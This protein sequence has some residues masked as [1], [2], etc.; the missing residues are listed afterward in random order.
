MAPHYLQD[1]IQACTPARPLCSA[2]KG[3]LAHPASRVTG[4]RSSRPRSFST[5]APQWWNN[6]PIPIRTAPSLPIFK[7]ATSSVLCVFACQCAL[8]S[9]YFLYVL[10]C[11]F[12]FFLLNSLPMKVCLYTL[13]RRAYLATFMDL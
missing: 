3:C 4:S 9:I 2:A 11:V 8:D 13:P 7:M 12:F 6:L 10:V 5:L 1:I